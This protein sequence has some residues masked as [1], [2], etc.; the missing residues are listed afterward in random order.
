MTSALRPIVVSG[1]SGSGKSTLLNRLFKEFPDCFAFSVSH[2]TR[3]PRKGEEDGKDYYFVKREEFEELIKNNGFLEYAQFSGNMYGTSKMAVQ[4]I[5]ESGKLCI[6]DVEINGV[7]S[8]KKAGM[9]PEPRFIFVKPPSIESLK[10]RLEGRGTETEESLKKRLETAQEAMDY[11]AKPG[12]YDHIIVNDDFDVA[13]EKL[14]GIL[15][16]DIAELKGAKHKARK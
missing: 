6:L 11:A 10:S 14:R 15:L 7:K 1:P 12:A 2:T 3:Q 8:I 9:K 16:E 13:Y 5:Q 4:T